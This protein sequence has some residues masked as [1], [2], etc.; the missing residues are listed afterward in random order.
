VLTLP[1]KYRES[2]LLFYFQEMDVPA[3][4]RSLGIAEGTLKARLSRGRDM[5]RRKLA[6]LVSLVAVKEMG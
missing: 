2:L 4:A 3:A 5:L 6:H 1:P